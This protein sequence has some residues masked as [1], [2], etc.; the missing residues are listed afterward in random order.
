MKDINYIKGVLNNMGKNKISV[1]SANVL[2]IGGVGAMLAIAGLGLPV[3]GV[4][5]A[6]T[7]AGCYYL[8]KK[9]VK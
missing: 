5:M 1:A 3:S 9:D 8:S 2:T 4:I 6:Y 7:I